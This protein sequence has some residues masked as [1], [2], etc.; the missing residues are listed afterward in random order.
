MSFTGCPVLSI[1]EQTTLLSMTDFTSLQSKVNSLKALIA[2]DS[3]SP[4]YLGGILDDIIQALSPIASF[5]DISED[6]KTIREKLTL[7][8]PQ[9]IDSEEELDRMLEAGECEPGRIY[10]T[11]EES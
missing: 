1:F 6:L 5:D 4:V 2:K 3:I 10:Y 8:I 11:E 7:L 9:R